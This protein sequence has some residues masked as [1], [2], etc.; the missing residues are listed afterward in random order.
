MKIRSVFWGGLFMLAGVLLLAS[1]LNILRVNVWELIWPT[2]IIAMGVWTLW[3]AK[4]G[5]EAMEIE[6]VTIPLDGIA[7][8]KMSIGFGAGQVKVD[9]SATAGNLLSGSFIGGLNKTLRRQDDA[10]ELEL[11]PA[12]ADFIQVIMPW[13]WG[14]REWKL[15]L[16][17]QVE[18]HLEIETG[19]SDLRMDLSNLRVV[20]LN[21]DTG[22]SNT[23]ITLPANAGHTHVD[24]DGG[25]ASIVLSI[26]EGVAARIQIDSGLAAISVDKNR[27]PRVGEYYK[28]SDYETAVNK[29]DINADFGAGSLSIR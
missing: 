10:A 16:N 21:I 17:D 12:D 29:M 11:K 22:A 20:D 8:A 15:G 9:N 5:T 25:A 24:V 4:Q 26:P 2:F 3:A 23:E 1:N 6:E 28:S 19:A 27:F 14:A 13:A 7:Q 18:W